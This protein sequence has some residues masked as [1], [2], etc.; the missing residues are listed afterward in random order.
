MADISPHVINAAGGIIYRWKD[1][2]QGPGAHTGGPLDGGLEVCVVH[3]P[4]YDDTS[5]P[6]GKLERNESAFHAAVREVGEET[7]IPVGVQS[8]LG[9]V[10]Y[11]LA[12]EGKAST[13]GVK[14]RGIRKAVDFWIMRTLSAEEDAL[15]KNAFGPVFHA[16]EGKISGVEWLP[17]REA[18]DALTKKSDKDIADEFIRRVRD[19][20]AFATT[21]LLVRHG[22]AENRKSWGAPDGMRPLMPRGA[23]S[24]Y[25][26]SREIACFAPIDLYSSPWKRCADTIGI[27]AMQSGQSVMMAP[28]LTEDAFAQDPDASWNA[29][30]SQISNCAANGRT[31]AVCM[32]RPVIGGCIDHLRELCE[33]EALAKLVPGNNP[34]LPTG[35]AVALS[36]VSTKNGP[37]IVDIQKVSPIVY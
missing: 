20:S 5:W 21:F 11:D 36:L 3:R 1:G 34:Y 29:L 33:S 13:K 17:P 31:S 22:K 37:R 7:G 6:K 16:D 14:K 26:L 12:F 4:K 9:H 35:H 27:Y 15:R 24:A 32:H 10:E 2:S 8:Y 25:A 19:G 30:Y 23:A 28:D 18:R